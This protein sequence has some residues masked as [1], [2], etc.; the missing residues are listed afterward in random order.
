[1]GI[2]ACGASRLLAVGCLGLFLASCSSSPAATPPSAA[3]TASSAAATVEP[4]STPSSVPESTPVTAQSI[5]PST[6]S[7]ATTTPLPP[8]ASRK[9]LTP[10][11]SWQWQLGG[12]KLDETVLDNVDNPKK[13]YD[14][15]LF[16]NDAAT[17]DR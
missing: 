2:T 5:G 17:I 3:P 13:M 6:D 15:D 8:W 12:G 4:T 1:M 7:S 16:T 14:I 11:T 10:G 9:Q